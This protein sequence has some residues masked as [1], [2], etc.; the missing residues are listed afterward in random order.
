MAQ[1]IARLTPNQEVASSNLA[2]GDF[3]LG[4]FSFHVDP[5][6]A[7][8]SNVSVQVPGKVSQLHLYLAATLTFK[9]LQKMAPAEH[10]LLAVDGPR[11]HT[12]LQDLSLQ[13]DEVCKAAT[14]L[15]SKLKEEVR[16]VGGIPVLSAKNIILA[17]YLHAL[18]AFTEGKV[19]GTL[20]LE[21]I[22]PC[23][24]EAIETRVLYDK[25]LIL[26][27]RLSR[28][29]TSML[30]SVV[31]DMAVK[32]HQQTKEKEAAIDDLLLDSSQ[33]SD[34]E[35]L[36]DK[37]VE[38]KQQ[39]SQADKEASLNSKFRKKRDMDTG[40]D[41]PSAKQL[42]DAAISTRRLVKQ[43]V[44]LDLLDHY[45]GRPSEERAGHARTT[46]DR[47]LDEY[48]MENYKRV[49]SGKRRELEK[50]ARATEDATEN[51]LD[52]TLANDIIQMG[53]NLDYARSNI[54]DTQ[55]KLDK[56]MDATTRKADRDSKRK[57]KV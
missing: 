51:L 52:S 17:K 39:E 19:A 8:W 12:V 18:A 37:M 47:E 26:E 56:L 13:I 31:S 32:V 9:W 55:S 54:E 22:S 30:Q 2:G 3:R 24:T 42:R 14:D 28:Q 35:E 4:L 34:N 46:I 29:I 6:D 11:L 25:A 45:E 43:G 53:K 38:R 10:E 15:Q 36:L 16:T 40:S 5:R 23:V 1:W 20:P 48:E 7:R 50:K 21:K 41:G 33:N 27:K 57:R 44:V 49:S